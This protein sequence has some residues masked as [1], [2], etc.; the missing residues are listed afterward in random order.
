MPGERRSDIKCKREQ[1]V[2]VSSQ[3]N[4]V[5]N[6]KF[7]I[8]LATLSHA[9]MSSSLVRN[10]MLTRLWWTH[11]SAA[12][13]AAV[14]RYVLSSPLCLLMLIRLYT[15]GSSKFVSIA[16]LALSDRISGAIRTT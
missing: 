6:V 15:A 13:A 1:K 5:M 11:L 7:A 10:I 14:S 16:S 12:A 3:V 4:A 2:S 9:D 8:I